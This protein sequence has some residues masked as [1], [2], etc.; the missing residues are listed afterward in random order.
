MTPNTDPKGNKTDQGAYSPSLTPP[1]QWT[2]PAPSLECSTL[3]SVSRVRALSQGTGAGP[4][5]RAP[6]CFLCLDHSLSVDGHRAQYWEKSNCKYLYAAAPLSLK[7]TA[8]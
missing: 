8:P 6:K 4:L 1:S 2:L 3:C 5:S 7:V